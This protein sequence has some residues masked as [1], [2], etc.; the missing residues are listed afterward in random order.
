MLCFRS[1]LVAKKF[2]DKKEGEVSRSPS[3]VFCLTVTETVVRKP[4]RVS[5]ISGIENLY[6]SE[7]YVTY[8]RRIFLSRRTE[9]HCRGTLLCCV[10][11]SFW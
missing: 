10:P 8:F 3:N 9:K 11:G 1:F 2:M 7:E 6:A 5:L 4:S